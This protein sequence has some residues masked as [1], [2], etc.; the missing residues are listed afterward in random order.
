MPWTYHQKSGAWHDPHGT[1]MH[2]GYSGHGFLGALIPLP[3]SAW[4]WSGNASRGDVSPKQAMAGPT[5]LGDTN[6]APRCPRT[7]P[8]G[9]AH[10]R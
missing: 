4:R 8:S 3:P 5:T 9:I 7:F 2:Y 6:S 10:I 1:L